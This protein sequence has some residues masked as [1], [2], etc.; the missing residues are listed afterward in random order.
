MKGSKTRP[1][2]KQTG[3]KKRSKAEDGGWRR[4]RKVVLRRRRGTIALDTAMGV[5]LYGSYEVKSLQWF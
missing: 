1:D 3:S 4:G 5:P 2:D